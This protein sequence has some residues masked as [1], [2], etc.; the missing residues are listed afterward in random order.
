M[1]GGIIPK[2]KHGMADPYAPGDGEPCAYCKRVMQAWTD[3]H[4]TKDH[5]VPRSKGGTDTVLCCYQC[6]QMKSD[7]SPEEWEAFM[8][9]NPSWWMTGRIFKPVRRWNGMCPVLK[10]VA[11]ELAHERYKHTGIYRET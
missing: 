1:P 2:G 8:R 10:V 11:N 7:G 6:N 9:T 5:V 3:T 4:P